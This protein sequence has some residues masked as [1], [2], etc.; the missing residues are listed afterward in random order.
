MRYFFLSF[1]VVLLHFHRLASQAYLPTVEEGKVYQLYWPMGMGSASTQYYQ[2][3]CDS[4]VGERRYLQVYLVDAD[5]QRLEYLGLVREDTLSQQVFFVLQGRE[6]E[7]LTAE[8]QLEKGDTTYR[9]NVYL[10]VDTVYRREYLGEMRKVIEFRPSEAY[11]E[12]IGYSLWGVVE[13]EVYKLVVGIDYAAPA[14][15]VT[16][17]GGY[18]EPEGWSVFPNPTSGRIWVQ[19]PAEATAFEYRLRTLGGAIVRTG[20][21]AGTPVSIDLRGLP[22]GSYILEVWDA[23]RR[24]VFRVQ[25]RP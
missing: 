11:V 4:L 12:G 16:S 7:L 21:T 23:G 15:G 25:K 19:S 1:M 22:P 5:Y 10:V 2:L 20:M 17:A 8:Y 3:G 9:Q 13:D 18:P 24:M 6:E 14:C